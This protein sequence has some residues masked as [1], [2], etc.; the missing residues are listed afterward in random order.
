MLET[1]SLMASGLFCPGFFSGFSLRSMTKISNQKS[2]S[3]LNEP[4]NTYNFHQYWSHAFNEKCV[5]WCFA[6]EQMHTL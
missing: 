6:P 1:L 2:P 5:N 3:K 4:E